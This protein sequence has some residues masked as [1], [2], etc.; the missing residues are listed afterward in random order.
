MLKT[1]VWVSAT[2]L[3]CGIAASAAT[4]ATDCT[5]YASPNGND[6]SSGL[7]AA[8]PKT[9][10][11]AGNASKPGSVVCLEGGSYYRSTGFSPSHDGSATGGYITYKAYGDA[12]VWIIYT[13]PKGTGNFIINL[14]SSAGFPNGRHFLKFID[15][16]LDGMGAANTGFFGRYCHHLVFANNYIRHTMGAGIGYVNCDYVISDHNV[17]WRNGYGNTIAAHATSGISY[18]GTCFYD[19][20]TG[21]HNYIVNNMISG[22]IDDQANTDGNGII[23]DLSCNRIAGVSNAN[24]P[25][26]LI[27]N[28]VIFMNGGNCIINF[29]VTDIYTINNTCYM[30]SLNTHQLSN[31]VGELGGNGSTKDWYINNLAYSWF[32]GDSAFFSRNGAMGSWYQNMWFVGVPDFTLTAVNYNNNPGYVSP[33]IVSPYATAGQYAGA[34]DPATI[35]DSFKLQASSPALGRGIDPLSLGGLDPNIVAGLRQHIYSDIDG[36]LRLQGGPFDL[37]AYTHQVAPAPP[38]NLN[39]IVH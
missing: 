38:T 24:T 15:L 26:A 9:L 2:I 13:G 27:L 5:L 6:S 25:P 3:G 17:I 31:H 18:N 32:N 34:P 1:L 21:F 28:N 23:F 19:K 7:T 10:N 20:Y 11:G 12:K 4:L 8:S 22:E 16:N 29:T 39:A 33:P 35:R 36:N 37:G 30:N 14:D